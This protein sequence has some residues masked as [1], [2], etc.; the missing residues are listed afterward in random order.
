MHRV[1]SERP[2][3]PLWASPAHSTGQIGAAVS[4]VSGSSAAEGGSPARIRS[5][6]RRRWRSVRDEGWRMFDFRIKKPGGPLDS[7]SFRDLQKEGHFRPPALAH[8]FAN[9]AR[10]AV[11]AV[12]RA[13]WHLNVFADGRGRLQTCPPSRLNA[14]ARTDGRKGVCVKLTCARQRNLPASR[15]SRTAP[16]ARAHSA[17]WAN[18]ERRG[19]D[20]PCLNTKAAKLAWFNDGWHALRYS[21]GRA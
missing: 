14:S 9:S 13:A 1:W 4:I 10:H 11:N 18:G 2:Q 17:T 21:E 8:F 16:P 5:T 7:N 20:S 6:A 19:D 15:G 12:V 3:I